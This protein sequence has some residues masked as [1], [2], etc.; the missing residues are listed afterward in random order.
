MVYGI[1]CV[2]RYGTGNRLA[3]RGARK[4][5]ERLRIDLLMLTRSS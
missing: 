1:P 5:L 2:S 3:R 4:R